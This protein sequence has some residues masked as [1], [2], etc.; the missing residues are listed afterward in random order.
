ME[1]IVEGELK[2][3]ED[4]ALSA[5]RTGAEHREEAL[6]AAATHASIALS[7]LLHVGSIT[8][9]EEIRWRERLGDALGDRRRIARRAFDITIAVAGSPPRTPTDEQR[10]QMAYTECRDLSLSHLAWVHHAAAIESSITEA[11]VSG[12][13]DPDR[14][15]RACRRGFADRGSEVVSPHRL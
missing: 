4:V 9:E 15:R 3:V 12:A 10:A 8:R 11:I 14:L 13:G 5:E 2:H 6:R 1:S 7:T